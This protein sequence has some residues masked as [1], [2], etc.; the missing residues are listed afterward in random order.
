MVMAPGP[1]RE[2]VQPARSGSTL[3]T[4]TATRLVAIRL[5]LTDAPMKVS[6]KI[7]N[8]VDESRRSWLRW[9]G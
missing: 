8:A 2:T 1:I 6:L 5:I 4:S 7:G 3:W 9:P